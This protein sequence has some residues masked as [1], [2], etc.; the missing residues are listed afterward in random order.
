MSALP[1]PSVR[2]LV[3]SVIALLFSV[4]R[5]DA[6]DSPADPETNDYWVE[7][8]DE[9]TGILVQTKELTL[10]P[11]AEAKPA[12]KHRLLL[13]PFER[14]RG[15]AAIFYLKAL[16][17]LEQNAA[18]DRIAQF[19][20]E[21]VA[22]AKKE[23]KDTRQLPPYV[24]LNTPPDKMP[25]EEVKKYLRL[26]SFQPQFI[27]EGARRSHFDMD[28]N[29]REVDDPIGYLLPE[30]QNLRE[31]ARTQSIRCR[32]AIAEG[33]IDDAIAT[34]EQALRKAPED[35]QS[36]LMAERILERKTSDEASLIDPIARAIS[37]ARAQGED[38]DLD[39]A[40]S[41]LLDALQEH[42]EDDPRLLYFLTLLEVEAEQLDAAG[43][44]L[45]RAIQLQPNNAPLLSLQ[46]SLGIEDPIERLKRAIAARYSD[47]PS[48][49][50]AVLVGLRRRAW[51]LERLADRHAAAADA[52]S[53]AS[54]R[55]LSARAHQEA[56][57]MLVR[58]HEVAPGHPMLLDHLIG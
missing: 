35:E 16:G 21:A 51:E 36:Q 26:T 4:A 47:E 28:R 50:L 14:T 58:A 3:C 15:N 30:I 37:N 5:S 8:R 25:R 22:R 7:Q 42:G 40:R 43:E 29:F 18:R 44:Y 53:E 17:F 52:A 57:V 24:W 20:K 31:L 19:R 27:R 46:A 1:Q 45:D 54:A 55:D 33:R 41:I 48:R 49:S 32:L 56:D 12:L 9:H 34:I 10:Y 23:G 11:A 6:Q 39:T 2:T 38:G 13:D